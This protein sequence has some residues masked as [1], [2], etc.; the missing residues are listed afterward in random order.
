MKDKLRIL[1]VVRQFYPSAGG[2][3]RF[4][5]EL[6]R[7]QLQAGYIVSVLTLQ[8][9]F[10]STTVF[11]A[12]E[13]LFLDGH[14]LHIRRLPFSGYARFFW[15]HGLEKIDFSVFDCVHLHG[16]DQFLTFFVHLKTRQSLRAKLILSTHGAFFHTRQF[17]YLKKLYFHTVI[18]K[19]LQH[20][21]MICACSGHDLVLFSSLGC[22]HLELVENGVDVQR[23]FRPNKI[24]DLN[25]LLYV[26]GFRSNKQVLLLLT[27]FSHACREWPDLF[28]TLVGTGEQKKIC[29]DF[30]TKN[31]LTQKVN[32]IDFLSEESLS[33][34]YFQAGVFISASNYE[35]FGLAAVEAM[36]SGCLLMLNDI[37]SFATFVP[38]QCNGVLVDFQNF[39]EVSE[40]YR[41][42]RSLSSEDLKEK[43]CH[44][45][46]IATRFDWSHTQQAFEK[47]YRLL[48]VDREA[49]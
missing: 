22:R 27:W 15:P 20:V 26:G 32:F 39:A 12:E 28:L 33:Q 49:I 11:P 2:M 40:Q 41:L 14:V 30:V 19:Q 29:L 9:Q 18:K 36:A 46:K 21:D 24:I 31:N 7:R 13:Q 37:D 1:H 4:V 3:E 38:E 10:N 48:L 8:R 34:V 5:Q 16:L 45:L 43:S 35:G 42:L 44:S 6:A 23:F 47:I 25:N 17:F